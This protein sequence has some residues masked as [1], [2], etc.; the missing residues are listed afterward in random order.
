VNLSVRASRS[1]VNTSTWDAL[2]QHTINCPTRSPGKAKRGC[3]VGE[4]VLCEL[5]RIPIPR[6]PVNKG[7]KRK[8]RGV[9]ATPASAASGYSALSFYEP[10]L[11][12][13]ISSAPR[14]VAS[15]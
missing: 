10:S 2:C 8:G 12:S 14:P 1:K 13:V 9:V 3:C 5:R 7:K 11:T 6:T 4:L 15:M